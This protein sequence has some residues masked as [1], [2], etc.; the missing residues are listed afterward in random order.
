[1]QRQVRSSLMFPRDHIGTRT[2]PCDQS[3]RGGAIVVKF[4]RISAIQSFLP[5]QGAGPCITHRGHLKPAEPG[6]ASNSFAFAPKQSN[7]PTVRVT[8]G[9][10]SRASFE[11]L[12]SL[13]SVDN[14]NA[15]KCRCAKT[16][17]ES[18][19]F[20]PFELPLSERQIPRF[21]GDVSSSKKCTE[22]LESR[23]VRPRQA[24]K[25]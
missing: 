14:R 9:Y 24:Q 3:S 18:N 1:M 20:D 7:A 13:S 12:V 25:R 16:V 23:V 22:L 10:C 6:F 2:L 21:V 19:V 11:R 8:A 15:A 5:P 17:P 4:V